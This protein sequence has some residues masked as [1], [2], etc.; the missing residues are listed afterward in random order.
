MPAHK[1]IE[2]ASRA[3]KGLST[4]GSSIGRRCLACGRS[5]PPEERRRECCAACAAALQPRTSGYC[6]LCGSIYGDPIEPPGRCIHCQAT[7]RPW[8]GFGF[9]NSYS[10]L[11]RE[12]LIALKFHGE[13]G[14]GRL[15]SGLLV[16]SFERHLAKG[17]FDLIVPVPMHEARLRQ[18]G[19]NQSV[20]LG[21]ALAKRYGLALDCSA[22]SR[23]KNTPPQA[24]LSRKERQQNLQGAFRSSEQRI[25]GKNVLLIDDI[26]TTGATVKACVSAIRKAG[27]DG[28]SVLVLARAQESW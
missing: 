28:V 10:G 26:Y 13:L 22:L 9:H 5:L 19:F 23:S 3:G 1:L 16:S 24:G 15:L 18:R 6:P 7:G 27:A 11:L 25:A 21:R 12:L 14:Y 2:L 4:L 20:E 17:R 8:D